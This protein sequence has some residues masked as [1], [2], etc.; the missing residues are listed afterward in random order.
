MIQEKAGQLEGRY[1]VSG[2]G[3]ERVALSVEPGASRPRIQFT[4]GS[5][6]TVSLELA[7][8]DWLSGKMT[9][10]GGGRGGGSSERP[11]ELQRKK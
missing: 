3:L 9:L 5:G 10:T 1:G 7:R 4:T 6:N 11:M 2:K 8:E